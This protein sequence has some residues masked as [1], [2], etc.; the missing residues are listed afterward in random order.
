[1]A[2]SSFQTVLEE[3]LEKL[4]LERAAQAESR[5][6]DISDI[7]VVTCDDNGRTPFAPQEPKIMILR[8]PQA[9]PEQEVNGMISIKQKQPLKTLE[10]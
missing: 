2:S 5:I 3:R 10:Q 8:R 6:Q 4:A 9:K 7:Q 1:M